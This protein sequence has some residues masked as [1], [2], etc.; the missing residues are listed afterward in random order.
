MSC[1]Y[2]SQSCVHGRRAGPV[3][4]AT[5]EACQDGRSPVL[6]A[7]QK[8]LCGRQAYWTVQAGTRDSPQV[9]WRCC[10]SLRSAPGQAL[11]GSDATQRKTSICVLCRA[12]SVPGRRVQVCLKT[13]DSQGQRA[14]L[15]HPISANVFK[16]QA[17]LARGA[18]V[19][20]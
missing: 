3:P 15:C 2:V 8:V 7:A 19:R 10:L 16:Q 12:L 18:R 20:S 9:T 1:V 14:A 11:R 17:Q 13:H 5:H 4:C 6:Q